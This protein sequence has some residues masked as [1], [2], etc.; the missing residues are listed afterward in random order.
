MLSWLHNNKVIFPSVEVIER[1]LAEATTLA[2]RAVFSALTEQL[3][4]GQRSDIADCGDLTVEYG[5]YRK[6]HRFSEAKRSIAQ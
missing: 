5:I 6:S 3:V 4:P 1:T 2:D